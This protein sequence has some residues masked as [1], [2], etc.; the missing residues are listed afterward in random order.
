[1]CAARDVLFFAE[2]PGAANFIAPLPGCLAARGRNCAVVAAGTAVRQLAQ[3]Q[4]SFEPLA[5]GRDEDLLARL[6]PR[7]VVVGTASDPDTRAL[8]LITAARRAGSVTVGVVDA[9][10]NADRRF[11]GRGAGALAC[12]P[13]WILVPDDAV[14][15]EFLRLG[16]S[17]ERVLALGHP[18]YDWVA[19]C[20]RTSQRGSRLRLRRRL[21]PDVPARRRIVLFVSEGSRRLGTP[22]A[23]ELERY[24]IRGHAT[25]GRSEIVLE[26][27]LRALARFRPRPYFMLRIHPRDKPR[28][29]AAY[30]KQSDRVS[31]REPALDCLQAADLVISATSQMLTEAALLGRPALAVIPSREELGWL[32]G[33]RNGA[34]PSATTR[35]EVRVQLRRLLTSGRRQEGVSARRVAEPGARGRVCEFLESLLSP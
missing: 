5:P 15:A 27:V 31:S 26:A 2:D 18:H 34:T 8:T 20:R 4:V 12:A 24:T 1:M 23:K 10:M 29:Y 13:D 28:D 7:V 19:D 14:R 30:R 35:A 32:P 6:Q 3:R 16:A 9:A 21:L 33:V 11:R 25:A 17:P 22:S